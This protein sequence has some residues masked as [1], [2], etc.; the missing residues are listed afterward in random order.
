MRT[1][2]TFLANNNTVYAKYLLGVSLFEYLRFRSLHEEAKELTCDVE[3]ARKI[4]GFRA[5][6]A[7]SSRIFE[8]FVQLCDLK[9]TFKKLQSLNKSFVFIGIL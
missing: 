5:N 4:T 3:L 1:T 7:A 8:H 2:K 6:S 9:W